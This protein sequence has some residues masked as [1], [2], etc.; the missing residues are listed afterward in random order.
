MIFVW[1]ARDILSVCQEAFS[2][3]AQVKKNISN[4]FLQIFKDLFR[5]LLSHG[6]CLTMWSWDEI[7]N[8]IAVVIWFLSVLGK[9]LHS[10]LEPCAT[11]F[12]LCGEEAPGVGK[13][14]GT[15]TGTCDC[16][17]SFSA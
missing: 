16:L 10:G 14:P 7:Q 1:K 4:C 3:G 2:A 15:G 17:T 8:Q 13:S 9:Q 6:G 12:L 11:H 5:V